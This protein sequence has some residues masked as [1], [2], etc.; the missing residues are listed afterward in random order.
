MKCVKWVDLGWLGLAFGWFREGLGTSGRPRRTIKLFGQ[1]AEKGI[2]LNRTG[3]AALATIWC[4]FAHSKKKE[5][6]QKKYTHTLASLG[7]PTTNL[8]SIQFL[9]VGFFV[10]SLSTS[11][12]AAFAIFYGAQ[13]ELLS[14]WAWC[15]G[16]LSICF[17]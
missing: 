11:R 14:V 9:S 3:L 1:R 15:V 17:S 2:K 5:T 16:V 6:K 12:P 4:T 10:P 13:I 8:D 7:K